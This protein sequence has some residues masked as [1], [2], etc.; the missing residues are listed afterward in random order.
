MTQKTFNGAYKS[1]KK[2]HRTSSDRARDTVK[3]GMC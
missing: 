3:V 2:G 1:N